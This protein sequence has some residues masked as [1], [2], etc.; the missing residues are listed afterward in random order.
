[1]LIAVYIFC[2]LFGLGIGYLIRQAVNS[3]CKHNWTL[4]ESNKIFRTRYN[5]KEDHTGYI[6]FYECE[7][8]K[9]L[10]K[11]QVELS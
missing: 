6:K 10:K 1:M 9:K 5:G 2:L 4:L 3:Q 8:C 11:E 7:H